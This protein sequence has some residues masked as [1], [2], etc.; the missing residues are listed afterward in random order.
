[1]GSASVLAQVLHAVVGLLRDLEN[2]D[3][4]LV[5]LDGPD[6]DADWGSL[7]LLVGVDDPA[8]GED[9]AAGSATLTYA[10][11]GR[12]AQDDRGS[13][14]CVAV[15]SSGDNDLAPLRRAAADVVDRVEVRLAAAPQS[16]WLGVPGALYGAVAATSLRQAFTGDGAEV[17]IPFTI[18]YRARV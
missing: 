14:P 7:Y 1:M 5:V 10:G 2:D 15:A 11:L 17:Q 4:G 8:N 3:P 16:P 12:G 9:L 6:P 13:I 18:T